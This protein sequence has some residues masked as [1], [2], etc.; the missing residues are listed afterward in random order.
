M[1]VDCFHSV[2]HDWIQVLSYANYSMLL[3]PLVRIEPAT[4]DDCPLSSQVRQEGRRVHRPKRCEYTNKD[5]DNYCDG[6]VVLQLH[7]TRLV[8]SFRGL[9]HVP[10]WF[11]L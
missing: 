11:V 9:P 7:N 2:N 6:F 5:E 3:T 1:G 4:S 10:D 8:D